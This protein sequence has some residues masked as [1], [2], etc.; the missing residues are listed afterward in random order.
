MMSA[1]GG[2]TYQTVTLTLILKCSLPE[3]NCIIFKMGAV[4]LSETSASSTRWQNPEDYH[5]SIIRSK[6]LKGKIYRIKINFLDFLNLLIIL[7]FEI[8]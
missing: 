2:M 7:S 5:L 3:S 6:S 4:R 8:Q 1:M